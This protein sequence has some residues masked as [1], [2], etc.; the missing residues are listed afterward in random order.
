MRKRIFFV[1]RATKFLLSFPE[2]KKLAQNSF[3]IGTPLSVACR[4]RRNQVG[5]CS[6]ALFNCPFFPNNKKFKMND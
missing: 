6:S 4:Y 1:Y 5:F 3:G 2:G